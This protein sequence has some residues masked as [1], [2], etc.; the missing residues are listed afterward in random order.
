MPSYSDRWGLSILG[1][2]D[3]LQDDG[4]KFTDSDRRL[5]DRLLQV[6]TETHRHT[7]GTSADN[8]PGAGPNLAVDPSGGSI[9]ASLRLY[10]QYTIVDPDGN[11]SAASPIA[12]IDTPTAVRE[13]Q[14]P[15][16]TTI[17]GSGNLEPGTYSYVCSA[18]V[19]ATTLETKAQNSVP[20]VVYG[21]NPSN[22]VQL[23]LPDLPLGASGLNIYRRAPSGLHYLWLA[24]VA[25]PSSGDQY[26]DD[27]TVTPDYDRTLPPSNRTSGSNAIQ[28]SLPGA[29]PTIADGW[30][31]RIYRTTTP[32]DWSRAYLDQ[33]NPEGAT[34][35]TPVAYVDI[36]AGT[37]PG[38]PP[39]AAQV[40]QSPPKIDL[41]DAAEITGSPPPGLLVTPQTI[42]FNWAGPVAAT[43][44]EFTWV[45][46]Y[47]QAD[48]IH[49]RAYLGVDSTPASVD[50]I[51]DVNVLRPS[52]GSSSWESAYSDGPN[53]PR[54][55][56]GDTIGAATVPDLVHLEAGDAISVDVDQAGGGATPT[57]TDLTVT[58]LLMAATGSTTTSHVWA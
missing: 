13:P 38:S 41:T 11:E 50:V 17:T 19:S 52:A 33:V 57:D 4:Y 40:I 14:A 44:G 31:W 56:V 37:L 48:I 8:T 20:A 58:V 2:G 27:G 34:P 53:R 15:T 18:Y 5:I 46:P 30:S 47:E 55:L 54:V 32:L 23:T 16:S 43:G 28:I 36:G 6:A 12:T 39:T 51:T 10:Y 21:T 45:C 26:L 3:S 1:P 49:C 29:T 35:S 9:A 42:S 7:G 22:S 25:A 24:S